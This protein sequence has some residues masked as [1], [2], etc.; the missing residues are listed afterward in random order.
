M[1]RNPSGVLSIP[2]LDI[3]N[4]WDKGGG[5]VVV[6]IE[7]GI[8]GVIDENFRYHTHITYLAGRL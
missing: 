5:A 2:L 6:A 8:R 3:C 7:S 1:F 4:V